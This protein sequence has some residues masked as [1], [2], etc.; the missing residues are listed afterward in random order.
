MVIYTYIATIFAVMDASVVVTSPTVLAA[1]I[2][3]PTPDPTDKST[4]SSGSSDQLSDGITIGAVIGGFLGIVFI[5]VVVMVVMVVMVRKWKKKMRVKDYASPV[6]EVK[7]NVA[8]GVAA[9]GGPGL[10][11]NLSY[12]A[13]SEFTFCLRQKQ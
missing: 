6:E 1:S 10:E 3:T 12:R 2:A 8:Y 7:E 5:V 9:T 11:N 4:S 13:F